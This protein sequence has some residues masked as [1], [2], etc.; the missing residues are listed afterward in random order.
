MAK[1]IF[2]CTVIRNIR[3]I[4]LAGIAQW[5]ELGPVNQ[6]VPSSIPHLGH[7]PGLY[8]RTPMVGT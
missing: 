5:I 1:L 7:M 8:M 6:R 3:N 4:A 2:Q